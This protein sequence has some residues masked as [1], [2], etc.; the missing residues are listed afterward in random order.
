[1]AERSKE[2]GVGQMQG[3][4]SAARGAAD[5]LEGQSPEMARAVRQAAEGLDRAAA[6][7]RGKS[8]GEIVD[9]C[10]DFARRQPAAYFGSA[11]LAGF[12]LTRFMKSR[13][14]RPAR[15]AEER[16]SSS[17]RAEQRGPGNRPAYRAADSTVT[18][19]SAIEEMRS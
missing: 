6:S 15:P 9:M 17:T 1:V 18:V 3:L 5:E 13:S 12:V 2:M 11:V 19:P 14:D 10:D 7:M 8:V 16:R 4:A